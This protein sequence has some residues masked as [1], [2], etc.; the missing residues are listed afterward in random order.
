MKNANSIFQA[1]EDT[2]CRNSN[3]R[4][5]GGEDALCVGSEGR[6][7]RGGGGGRESW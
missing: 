4:N 6:S 3:V 2:Q 7:G 5:R 1:A